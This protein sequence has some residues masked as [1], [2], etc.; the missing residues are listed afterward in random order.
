MYLSALVVQA[1]GG[2]AFGQLQLHVGVP[3]VGDHSAVDR[4]SS[5]QSPR[6]MAASRQERLRESSPYLATVQDDDRNSVAS[7]TF[8]PLMHNPPT[9]YRT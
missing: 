6:G 5:I 3:D 7:G 2:E 8:F 4:V 1:D 9:L